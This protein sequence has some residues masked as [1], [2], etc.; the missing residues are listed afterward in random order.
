[1]THETGMNLKTHFCENCG[2]LLY[3]TADRKEFEGAV[4][5]LAGT[6]DDAE[7]FEKAKPE[8]EFFVKHRAGWWPNLSFAT[9]LEDFD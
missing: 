7:D 6:L 3:K 9:Q 5:V 4:I 2:G 1:M 8:A